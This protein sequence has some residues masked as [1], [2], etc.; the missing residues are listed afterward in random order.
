MPRAAH[1]VFVVI[2]LSA[3]AA[4][5]QDAREAA[6]RTPAERLFILGQMRLFLRSSQAILAALAQGD[7]ITVATQAA[8]R[9]RSGTPVTD[10]PPDMKAKETAAWTALMGG[11]RA[12]FDGIAWAA[13][14][15]A[16]PMQVLRTMGETMRNCIACH[17]TYRLADE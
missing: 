12:G 7:M 10:I 17:Q 2:L 16:E 9:G 4:P 8:A 3:G 15:G 11:A 13:A 5:A 1:I 14:A 6:V